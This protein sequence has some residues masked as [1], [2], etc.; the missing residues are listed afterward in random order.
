MMSMRA[1]GYLVPCL[2][3]KRVCDSFNYCMIW[4][5]H[6]C[7]MLLMRH[8]DQRPFEETVCDAIIPNSGVKEPSKKVQNVA[9]VIQ[10]IRFS[11]M[12]CL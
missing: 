11:P 9:C 12:N 1:L 6:Y 4:K 10:G 2:T 7:S 8:Y 5:L 3:S